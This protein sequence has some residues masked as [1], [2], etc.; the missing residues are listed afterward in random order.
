[1]SHAKVIHKCSSLQ[2]QLRSQSTVKHVSQATSDAFAPKHLVL[3][4][5][6]LDIMKQ[7]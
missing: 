4:A 5:E 1:M 6:V 2:V 7:K 3:P